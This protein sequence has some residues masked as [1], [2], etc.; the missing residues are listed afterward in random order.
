MAYFQKFIEGQYPYSDLSRVQ[1]ANRL[2]DEHVALGQRIQQSKTSAREIA[3]KKETTFI[4]C[5]VAVVLLIGNF[6]VPVR[7][8]S[9]FLILSVPAFFAIS[10]LSG[11]FEIENKLYNH[12]LH[13]NISLDVSSKTKEL[14]KLESMIAPL[15]ILIQQEQK[16]YRDYWL[17][18]SAL[19]FEVEVANLFSNV[20]YTTRVTKG[21]GDGGI[22]IVMERDGKVVIVQ[23]KLHKKA[24]GPHVV[25]DLYGA[26]TNMNADEAILVSAMGFTSG[27]RDFVAGKPVRLLS[28][29]DILA[30]AKVSHTRRPF[31]STAKSS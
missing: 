30:L 5:V 12:E 3:K 4:L 29:D 17:S 1:T 13:N 2:I 19:Q 26:L 24:V 16:Q 27:V 21:S 25:R 7:D 28:L 10:F 14:E 9:G 20:G 18:M 11:L 8:I 31:K 15:T 6:Q 22:D 23:C